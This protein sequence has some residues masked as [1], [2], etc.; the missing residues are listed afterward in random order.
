MGK[1]KRLVCMRRADGT[2]SRTQALNGIIGALGTLVGLMP[3]LQS[4][5]SPSVYPW[6]FVVLSVIYS[7]LRETTT[8]GLQK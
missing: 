7:Y 6:A 8:Q 5:I 3:Q 2:V 1:G 4:Q